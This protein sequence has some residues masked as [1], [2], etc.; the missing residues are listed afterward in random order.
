MTFS[1]GKMLSRRTSDQTVSQ[2]PSGHHS[3]HS[4]AEHHKAIPLPFVA[5][6]VDPEALKWVRNKKASADGAV[7]RSKTVAQFEAE[8]HTESALANRIFRKQH[9]ASSLELFFDLFFVA[10]LAIFTA[11]SSHV[12]WQCELSLWLPETDY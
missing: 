4:H 9:E 11:R 7:V 8:A 5:S 1:L 2:V 6:P 10:N 3:E 12:D